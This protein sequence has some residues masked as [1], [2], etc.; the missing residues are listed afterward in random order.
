[1]ALFASRLHLAGLVES[2]SMS[3]V[4]P[5]CVKDRRA[6]SS[7]SSACSLVKIAESEDSSRQ[8]LVLVEAS[9]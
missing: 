2:C 6:C 4:P 9:P 8:H 5:S 7:L 3:Y 1:M